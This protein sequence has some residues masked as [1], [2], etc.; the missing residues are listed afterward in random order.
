M[1]QARK[2][3]ACLEAA[4]NSA[5]SVAVGVGAARRRTPMSSGGG[6]LLF[7]GGGA[8]QFFLDARQLSSQAIDDVKLRLRKVMRFAFMEFGSHVVEV[9][10]GMIGVVVDVHGG[11]TC[12]RNNACQF[13]PRSCGLGLRE[14]DFICGACGDGACGSG[15]NRCNCASDCH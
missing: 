5:L 7:R 1:D 14:N 3:G 10:G 12:C 6:Q 11:A 8:V 9:G 15:E 13:H 2:G 4:G